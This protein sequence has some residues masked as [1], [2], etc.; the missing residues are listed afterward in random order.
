MVNQIGVTVIRFLKISGDLEVEK[1]VS[2]K[3]R[4]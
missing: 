2:K 4:V 3:Q 1:A